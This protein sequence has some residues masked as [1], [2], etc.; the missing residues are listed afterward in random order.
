MRRYL[1]DTTPLAGYLLGRSG[2]VD[3]VNP[4][5]DRREVA[6]SLLVYGEVAEYLMGRRDFEIRDTQLRSLLQDITPY[7]LTYATLRRYAAIRRQM[8]PPHGLGLIGDVDT[9]IAAT[10][11]ERALTVVTT[12]ADLTRVPNLSVMLLDR[13]TLNPMTDITSG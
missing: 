11:L 3:L 2:I 10:A 9:L 8:R 1:L 5:L 12:D 7:F 13:R 4:W 6:T